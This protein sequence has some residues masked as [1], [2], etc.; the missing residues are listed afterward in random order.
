M[1]WTNLDDMAGFLALEYPIAPTSSHASNIQE[2]RAI[3][4]VI[5]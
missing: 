5:I 3:D 2:L 1:H 4:E